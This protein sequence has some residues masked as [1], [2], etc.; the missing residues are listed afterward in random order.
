MD[1]PTDRYREFWQYL[2][3]QQKDLILEGQYL[4]ND[5]LRNNVYRFKDYSFLVFPFAK[6]YE[7]FLKQLFKE[8][9]FISHLDYIS[10]H[11][12]LG[13]LMSPNLEARLG[14][15]SL[16]KKMREK[17]NI[18]FA[19]KVWNTWKLGRNQIFHYFPHNTRAISF[20]EA[21]KI[22]GQIIETMEDVYIKLKVN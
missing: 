8:I 12:R 9:K 21:E 20:T 10:D 17:V 14:D 15:R 2:S 6:A 13:K 22:I 1:A 3:Q 18:D 11:L 4:M 5:V 19:E 7:G 16:Y